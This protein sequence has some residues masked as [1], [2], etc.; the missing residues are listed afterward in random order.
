MNLIDIQVNGY[1]GVSFLGDLLTEQQV[2]FVAERLR[3]GGVRAILPT[4]TTDDVELIAARV[5]NF[6]KIIDSDASLREL[7]PAFH[8]EGPCISPE[9]G[10]RGAHSLPWIRPATPEFFK[11]ILEAAGGPDRMKMVTLAPECD[12]G[13]KTTR[14][15]AEQGVIV[16]AGHTNAP[17][18]VL[19]DS[20]EAGVRS[21]THLGNGSAAMM[22]RHDNII[23]RALSIEKLMVSLIPDGFHI[24]WFVLKQYIK[25]AG[26]DRC[27]FTTDCVSPADAPPGKFELLRGVTVEV[28]PEGKVC[29]PGTPY[30]AGSA[31]TMSKGYQNAIEFLGLTPAQASQL[32]TTNPAK[33]IGLKV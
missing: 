12:A 13:L 4:I 20:V 14:F 26:L 28:G 30:L 7:M 10:Y 25:V 16:C 1:A 17:L 29:M 24:P 6:R 2:R 33:L 31:L 22:P 5:A 32:W 19:R 23:N 8:I 15:L 18:D 27:I 11:P 3:A 9:D 21:F